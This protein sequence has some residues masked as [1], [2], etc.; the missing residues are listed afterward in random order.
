MKAATEVQE[1][2]VASVRP[3]EG[4]AIS[5]VELPTSQSLVTNWCEGAD[6]KLR[7]DEFSRLCSAAD[8]LHRQHPFYRLERNSGLDWTPPSAQAALMPCQMA[9]WEDLV[10][11]LRY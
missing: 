7:P 2:I 3:R 6:P 8:F 11:V 9:A 10:S 4:C 5:I 1:Q